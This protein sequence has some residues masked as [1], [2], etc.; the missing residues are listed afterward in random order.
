MNQ[1]HLAQDKDYSRDLM[2]L[3]Y[4]LFHYAVNFSGCI[5]SNGKMIG[6]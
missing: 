4:G 5:A 2:A 1:I 6:Q 3:Y